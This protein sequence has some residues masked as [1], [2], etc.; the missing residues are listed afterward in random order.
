VVDWFNHPIHGRSPK[1]GEVGVDGQ[2]RKGG[3]FEPFYVPRQVMPQIDEADLLAFVEFAT[4]NGVEVE[5]REVDIT[6]LK[7][8]QRVDMVK[9]HN[10]T[11]D[12]L[13][14]PLL[15]SEDLFVLD[16]N[17]RAVGHK[18]NGTPAR[19]LVIKAVFEQAIGLLFSFPGTYSYGDGQFHPIRN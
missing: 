17:H 2:Y 11:E 10:L 18:L 12:E 15:V 5:D 16:G 9:V 4:F 14:K 7:F 6:E 8:H 1:G 19:C 3:E 13:A